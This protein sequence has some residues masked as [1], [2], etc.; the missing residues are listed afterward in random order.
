LIP[1]VSRS[2]HQETDIYIISFKTPALASNVEI[3]KSRTL[4][5]NHLLIIQNQHNKFLANIN[6]Q[7]NKNNPILFEY[8]IAINAISLELSESEATFISK[9]DEVLK[10]SK[11]QFLH[12][13]TDATASMI[14]ADDMWTG[15]AIMPLSGVKG[16]DIVIGIIDSGINANH[17]SFNDTPQDNYDFA[18]HNPFGVDVFKGWCDVNH[19]NYDI[20]YVC[21]NKLI[22]MWDY[23]DVFGNESDGPIDSVF[24]GSHM[25]GIISGNTLSIPVGGFVPFV[26]N[27]LNAP[28]ISGVAPHSHFI[29]Y[30]VCDDMSGC[31]TSAVLAAI[32]QAILDN[33][34]II[35]L[36]L[37]GGLNPWEDN[38]VALALLNANNLGIIT[39]AAAGNA[40]ASQPNPI[41]KV[42]NL[43]P[44]LLTTANSFHG[45]TLSND[46]SVTFPMPIPALLIE[47][48]SVIS[49]GVSF[50]ANLNSK[51]IYGK[52]INSNNE[53]GCSS[54]LVLDFDASIALI[55]SGDC[56]NELKVQNAEDAGAIAVIIFNA[57]SDI[58]ELMTGIVSPTIP[59]IMIGLTDA[60]NIIAHIQASSPTDTIVE[61]L[62]QT[63]HKIVDALG[64][65]LYHSS[66]RGPNNTFNLTK[67]DIT[68]P[69]TNIFSAMAALNGTTPPEYLATTGT[70]QSTAAVTGALALLKNIHPTWSP[71]ELKSVVMLSAQNSIV[72]EDGNVTSA[73]DVG[74]GMLNIANAA[75]TFLVLNESTINYTNANPALAGKPKDLNIASLRN[76][77][78]PTNCSW[79]R[80][81]TNKDTISHSWDVSSQSD[82]GSTIIVSPSSFT[83]MPAQSISL[84]IEFNWLSGDFLEYRFASLMLTDSDGL[85]P[86][87]Q[88]TVVVFLDDLIFNNGFE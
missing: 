10:I 45:R 87:S 46:V 86:A 15:D 27:T 41:G 67:P 38:S 31:P 21:N 2:N 71:S 69:G 72:L 12:I 84:N 64:L 83:L 85:M 66:L 62:A 6:N 77:Q 1:F 20:S 22:G 48:Y 29:M 19:P 44:W 28:F 30:D 9:F 37:S 39:A 7:F 3:F 16:E 63:T 33:V 40:T 60:N 35:N 59:A 49:D 79:T 81:L 88:L 42:N 68:A 36:S 78:C 58:P 76:N 61:I 55:K 75:N 82:M 24:H 50:V 70:S 54:W 11:Q 23:V 13:T 47:I 74:S 17:E 34:D 57:D 80:T 51:I 14:N 18:S 4:S 26:G 32:E 43:A 56:S 5:K 25:A 52:D 8:R 65:V 53:N 73:D